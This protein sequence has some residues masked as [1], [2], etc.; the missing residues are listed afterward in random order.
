M[1]TQDSGVGQEGLTLQEFHDWRATLPEKRY[2]EVTAALI[3]FP[4]T[5]HKGETQEQ[6]RLRVKLT[7]LEKWERGWG[8]SRVTRETEMKMTDE[9]M[10]E[11][12]SLAEFEVWCDSLL[13]DRHA[14]V[15]EALLRMM[16]A[17]EHDGETLP[18][19]R[20][21]VKKE[22]VRQWMDEERQAEEVRGG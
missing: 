15:V 12:L 1:D 14:K 13:I 11:E 2:E 22:V 8:G 17:P 9:E 4:D 10:A 3:F 18:E 19:F 16:F 7:L 21:R 6:L 20:L 5:E